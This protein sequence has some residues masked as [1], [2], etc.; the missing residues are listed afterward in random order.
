MRLASLLAVPALLA[1]LAMGSTESYAISLTGDSVK[2][3]LSTTY[4]GSYGVK[5]AVV[6]PGYEFNYFGNQSIDVD[7]GAGGD[8]LIISSAFLFC[9]IDACNPTNKVTLSLTDLNFGGPF[10]AAILSSIGNAF[11]SSI[12]G[13]SVSFTWD[14]VSIP[15][16]TYFVAKF[17]SGTPSS[18]PVPA[19]LPLL[20]TG[21]LALG[22]L[23]RRKA[24]A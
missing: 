6:G 4:A 23:A 1:G 2:V 22:A 13:T 9:G 18:V 7:F 8:E 17:T 12:S 20:A 14:D 24:S 3:E 21:L 19:A 11:V 5:T 16:G 15:Q 10:T